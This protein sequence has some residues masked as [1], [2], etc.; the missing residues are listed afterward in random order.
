MQIQKEDI[1]QKIVEIA[2]DEFIVNGFRDASM[3]IIA[4][5]SVITLSNIYNYFKN[6]DELFDEVL[7]PTLD[8]LDN[9]LEGH[10]SEENMTTEYFHS[11][12]KQ[13]ENLKQMVSMIEK[14]HEGL[15]LL[16]FRADG[17]SLE[18]FKE[19]ITRASTIMGQEYLIKMKE[20]YPEISIDISPF[21]IHFMS[22]MWLNIMTEIIFHSLSHDQITK[23]I[24]EYIEFGT[25]GWERIMKI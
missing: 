18:N 5:R 8:A 10:N 3:R 25:A 15:K 24:S 13:Q 4:A 11:K 22:S 2:R 9:M 23:F 6:K 17:S 14:H 12:E 20:K 16:L 19:E 1:R 21:F 7:K